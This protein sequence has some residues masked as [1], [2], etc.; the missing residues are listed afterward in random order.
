[1][2]IEVLEPNF[3]KFKQSLKKVKTIDE[4]M[5]LHDEFLENCLKEC[6]LTDQYIYKL[7]SQINLRQHFF[8]KVIIRF[9]MNV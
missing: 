9:F 2:L 5:I 7:I 6:L 1:M 4:I 8:S 3:H